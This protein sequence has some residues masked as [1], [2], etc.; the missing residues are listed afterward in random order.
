MEEAPPGAMLVIDAPVSTVQE[1][2]GTDCVIA[3]LNAAD[4]I[5][6]AGAERGV[7]ELEGRLERLGASSRRLAVDRAFHSPAME[8]VADG[9][10]EAAARVP[11]RPPAPGFVSTVGPLERVD[12]PDHWV[13][14]LLQPVRFEEAVRE[15]AP[16]AGLWLEL[17]PPTLLPLVS[18]ILRRPDEL[19][20]SLRTGRPAPRMMVE[21]V[22]RL[23]EAG[24]EVA[25][26]E[27]VAPLLGRRVCLPPLP[28]AGAAHGLPGA[29][30]VAEPSAPEPPRSDSRERI[31]SDDE[32]LR[33]MRVWLDA[34]IAE[35]MGRSES[36]PQE[37]TLAELGL[38]SLMIGE[39]RARLSQ[40][41]GL[42]LHVHELMA[43]PSVQALSE[44]LVQE[45]R[46]HERFVA[47]SRTAAPEP[48]SRSAV[49]D[50]PPPVF[51]FSTGRSGST[52]FRVMLEGH[53]ELFAPPSLYLLPFDTIHDAEST[54]RE[55]GL[56]MADG[57]IAAIGR[58]RTVSDDEAR[59]TWLQW[60]E[61][62][63]SVADVYAQ[64]R[65]WAGPR[66]L[67][68]KTPLYALDPDV[69]RRARALFPEARVLH[70]VRHPY[71]VI[72]SHVRNRLHRLGGTE[73]HPLDIGERIWREWNEHIDS[74]VTE[75]PDDAWL[76]VKYEDLV[77]APA[78]TMTR[79][80][81]FLGLA[82]E[83]S[84]IRPYNGDRMSRG[85]TDHSLPI[86]DPNFHQHTTIDPTLGDAWRSI[87]LP[88]PLE[89]ATRRLAERLGYELPHEGTERTVAGSVRTRLTAAMRPRN[90]TSPE[91]VPM[92]PGGTRAPL[93][94]VH[95]GSGTAE[96]FLELSRSLDSDQPVYAFRARGLVAGEQPRRSVEQIAEDYASAIRD[97]TRGGPCRLGGYSGGCLIAWELASQL[98]AMGIEVEGL[99]MIEGLQLTVH[100]VP[101]RTL[102]P[103][104]QVLHFASLALGH[105]L[106]GEPS[107]IDEAWSIVEGSPALR[108]GLDRDSL[109]SWYGA[110]VALAATL[111][112]Y[113]PTPA[114]A[115]PLT[116]FRA[117]AP[118]SFWWWAEQ[119][120]RRVMDQHADYGWGRLTNGDVRVVEVPGRHL[121]VLQAPHV[122]VLAHQLSEQLNN[123]PNRS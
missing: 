99:A 112:A 28:L 19:V 42:L 5:V 55:Q 111:D 25:V 37:A 27:V 48:T 43:T 76:R 69:M 14:H 115:T 103:A 44:H 2:L 30:A 97:V 96:V 71:A 46:Y 104:Q 87:R 108:T 82:Y 105:T 57:V 90:S 113:T 116:L 93:F 34:R 78:R 66:A 53:S 7:R 39:L 3:A 40:D 13:R 107:D 119:D 65:A 81:A 92:S 98:E 73:G 109:E 12:D 60:V 56:A 101:R 59:A 72:E 63:R 84:I 8:P 10:R 61:E 49:Q 110:A 47:T 26:G 17:G 94:L 6:V 95:P 20:P 77:T 54:L 100:G 70:L 32:P 75:L 4:S 121:T 120:V 11:W 79:V 64:L 16:K 18:R 106:T 1:V 9:V 52:L 36:A 22:G 86:G 88:R 118:S 51:V 123:W 31:L 21:A 33:A 38:D 80:C 45:L 15:V 29:E 74:V 58:L 117:A 83:D 122:D 41:L 67:V 68:D 102:Q 50:L 114:G 35:V 85:A 24:C 23:F 91:L 62:R 89:P